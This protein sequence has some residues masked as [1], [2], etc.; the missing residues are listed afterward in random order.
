MGHAAQHDPELAG[1]LL[2][3][4]KECQPGVIMNNRLGGGVKGDID[5]P[6]QFI[7][8]TGGPPGR[9]WETCMTMNNTWVWAAGHRLEKHRRP[10]AQAA[11]HLPQGRN[12]LLNVG[13]TAEGEIPAAS[14]ERLRDIGAWL[15][16]NGESVYGT[17]ASP[18]PFLSWG[19]CTRRGNTLYL[20]VF[21]WPANGLRACPCGRASFPPPSWPIRRDR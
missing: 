3:V 9:D 15:R 14:V 12:F 17:T 18:M 2:D 20:H 8:S 11:R 13:P 21:D 10:A 4:V 6:E 1:R 5:T 7:P 16:R 19:R